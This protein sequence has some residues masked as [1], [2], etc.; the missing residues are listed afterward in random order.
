[1]DRVV[2]LMFDDVNFILTIHHSPFPFVFSFLFFTLHCG[3]CHATGGPI[4]RMQS[5]SLANV[6]LLIVLIFVSNLS[7]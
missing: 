1:M 4:F 2:L 6:P 3:S 5:A 7:P